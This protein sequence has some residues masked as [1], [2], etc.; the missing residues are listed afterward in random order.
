MP[1]CA[2]FIMS[3]PWLSARQP[4]K[5]R[6]RMR[7][8]DP[9]GCRGSAEPGRAAQKPSPACLHGPARLGLNRAGQGARRTY[10]YLNT[11][12][13]TVDCCLHFFFL[14]CL[15]PSLSLLSGNTSFIWLQAYLFDTVSAATPFFLGATKRPPTTPYTVLRQDFS[16]VLR[17][18]PVW[19]QILRHNKQI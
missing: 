1:Q 18:P 7:R 11:R 19:P 2:T 9:P 17:A 10:F 16:L 8:L 6:A 13:L 5:Q 3:R 12:Q 4:A 14:L 15:P